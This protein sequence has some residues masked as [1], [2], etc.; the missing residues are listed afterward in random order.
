[1]PHSTSS[2]SELLAGWLER[3]DERAFHCLVERYAGLVHMAALRRCGNE[4]SAVEISQLTFISLA[5]KARVLVSRSSLAG[6]LHVTAMM[7]AKNHLRQRSREC[8]KLQL[9]QSHMDTDPHLQAAEDWKRIQPALDE[10][11][12]ALSEKDRETLLLRFYRSLSVREIADN[13][14]IATDAAQKRLSRATERLRLQLTRRGCQT[15]ASLVA[16]MIVGFGA[17]AKAVVPGASSFA[18]QAIAV[19][20]MGGGSALTTIG[21][22]IMTKK[23]TIAA[24]IAL[25]MAGVGTV[26]LIRQNDSAPQTNAPLANSHPRT[27]KA[28]LKETSETLSDGSRKSRNLRRSAVKYP[29]L[30]SKFGQSR[31]NLSKHVTE[32]V[33]GLLNDALEMSEMA[34][35][36]QFSEMVGGRGGALRMVL[37]KLDSDL[38]LTD[39]QRKRAEEMFSGHQ[40]TQ[41]A[42]SKEA[43]DH[44]KK[45]PSTLMRLMLVSDAFARK[46]INETEFKAMQEEASQDLEGLM[47]PFDQRNLGNMG[48]QED[49][50]FLAGL[51]PLLDESQSHTLQAYLDEKAAGETQAPAPEGISRMA[52]MELEKLDSTVL[53]MKKLTTGAKAML[54]GV[55]GLQGLGPVIE[56]QGESEKVE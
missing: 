11:L 25:L 39:D 7:H 54:E 13:L 36:D 40:K 17:D 15:G 26:A 33:I 38:K 37:G 52:A 16:A 56:Q 44:L 29:E 46:E 3:R 18:S 45:D 51:K 10:A 50:D 21:I 23:T 22:I 9:F 47:N 20:T 6:W 31:T 32:N 35:S 2:D 48:M 49:V 42:K 41:I 24:G 8:R 30:T 4:S 5:R 14:G 43:V 55:G 12:A 28:S 34:M 27:K 1:M 53:S 19:G